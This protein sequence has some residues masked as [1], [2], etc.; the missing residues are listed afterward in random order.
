MDNHIVFP[1]KRHL[2]NSSSPDI[3]KRRT[4]S[5]SQNT[6]YFPSSSKHYRGGG[7]KVTFSGKNITLFFWNTEKVMKLP[8]I[9]AS[10]ERTSYNPSVT[11]CEAKNITHFAPL[12][13]YIP[14]YK[15]ITKLFLCHRWVKTLQKK[16]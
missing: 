7:K 5:V 8:K 10:P 9:R 12:N 11:F 3:T 14:N 13:K 16:I 1:P 6:L 2:T 15:L 4:E